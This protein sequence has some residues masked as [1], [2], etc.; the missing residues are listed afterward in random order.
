MFANHRERKCA[1]TT[2]TVLVPL[3]GQSVSWHSRHS[4]GS[5]GWPFSVLKYKYSFQIKYTEAILSVG[6]WTLDTSVTSSC[7]IY[8]GFNIQKIIKISLFLTEK[9]L[10]NTSRS[11]MPLT[12]ILIIIII[13]FPSPTLSFQ[14]WNLPFLQILP[15][16]AS[17]FL[18]QNWLHDSPDFYCYL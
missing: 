6:W 1:D 4:A 3:A 17:L 5:L 11:F 14:T 18:L 9:K 12:V 16:A 2:G 8:S 7:Q 13:S 15:T 10:H